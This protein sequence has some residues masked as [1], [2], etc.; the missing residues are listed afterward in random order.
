MITGA[1]E[2]VQAPLLTLPQETRASTLP[3]SLSITLSTSG[4]GYLRPA[5]LHG[6]TVVKAVKTITKRHDV[7][8]LPFSFLA[9]R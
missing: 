7:I 6:T 3:P 9:G 1:Q 2:G 4:E 8:S 5:N